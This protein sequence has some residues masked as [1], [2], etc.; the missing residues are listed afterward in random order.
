MRVDVVTGREAI[1]SG[2]VGGEDECVET[3]FRFGSSLVEIR[4]SHDEGS[5]RMKT[6]VGADVQRHVMRTSIWNLRYD[7]S[8]KHFETNLHVICTAVSLSMTVMGA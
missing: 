7:V 8:E 1:K 4:H 2:E 6:H 3:T 5:V